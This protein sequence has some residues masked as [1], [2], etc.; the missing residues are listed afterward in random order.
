MNF[1]VWGKGKIFFLLDTYVFEPETFNAEVL[2]S[3]PSFSVRVRGSDYSI[4]G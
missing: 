4:L 1:Y 3:N 2:Y